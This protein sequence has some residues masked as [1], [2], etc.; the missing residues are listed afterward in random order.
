MTSPVIGD[1]ERNP[2]RPNALSG[3]PSDDK[4]VNA[5]SR[6]DAIWATVL[7][8]IALL[9]RRLDDKGPFPAWRRLGRSG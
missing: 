9:L 4:I 5:S 3:T 8:V 1:E 2:S 7:F 6:T